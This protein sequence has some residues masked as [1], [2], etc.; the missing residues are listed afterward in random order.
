MLTEVSDLLFDAQRMLA[1]WH[2]TGRF[3]GAALG[4]EAY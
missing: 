4:R 2:D 3:E 1:T